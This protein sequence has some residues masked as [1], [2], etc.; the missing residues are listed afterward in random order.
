MFCGG[1]LP[2]NVFDRD[3]I[4]DHQRLWRIAMEQKCS[5]V[6]FRENSEEIVGL[7][8]HTVNTKND[9][10]GRERIKWV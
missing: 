6:C 8:L 4:E 1:F 3:F 9:T 7:N 2:D 10:L 5:V